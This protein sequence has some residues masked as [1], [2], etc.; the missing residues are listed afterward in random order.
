MNED[1]PTSKVESWQ[2]FLEVLAQFPRR[3]ETPD[4]VFRGQADQSWTL[5]PTL[6]RHFRESVLPSQALRLEKMVSEEFNAHAHL[7]LQ[8]NSSEKAMNHWYWPDRWAFM[9]HYGVPTRLIDWSSSAYVAAYFATN[10]HFETDGAIYVASPFGLTE[11]FG[12][13]YDASGQPDVPELLKPDAPSKLFFFQP[14]LH[15]E[16]SAL[17]QG[18][19]SVNARILEPHDRAILALIRSKRGRGSGS[20]LARRIVIP[21][22]LKLSFL[23]ELSRMNVVPRVL[24]PGLDGLGRSLSDFLRLN[25]EG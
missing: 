24:F 4:Y 2:S 6:Q 5:M 1:W 23:R 22:A 19:F 20:S 13:G 12:I 15:S 9:A 3:N 25:A 17:Q 8:S 16:R 14:D 21:A 7:F 11:L 18:W 10:A